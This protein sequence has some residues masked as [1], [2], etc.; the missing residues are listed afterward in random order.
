[1]KTRW[2][3]CGG[4]KNWSDF[5]LSY[6]ACVREPVA[7]NHHF[8]ETPVSLPSTLPQINQG[9]AAAPSRHR[10]AQDFEACSGFPFRLV[11]AMY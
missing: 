1:M 3:F 2:Q 6:V 8:M 4:W 11:D 5:D 9:P 10:P 7:G